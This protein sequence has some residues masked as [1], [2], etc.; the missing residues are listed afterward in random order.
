MS[1]MQDPLSCVGFCTGPTIGVDYSLEYGTDRIEMHVGA[2]QAG[3]RVVIIDDLIATGGT[4]GAGI[5]LIGAQHGASPLSSHPGERVAPTL[6][7]EVPAIAGSSLE[8]VVGLSMQPGG[9]A[10]EACPH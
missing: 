3:E 5:A 9:N 2:L 4:M 10:A 1:S 7:L 6:C 8:A